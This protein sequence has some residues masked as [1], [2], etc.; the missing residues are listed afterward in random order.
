MKVDLALA[1]SECPERMNVAV[2]DPAPVFEIDTQLE[3]GFGRAHEVGFVDSKA[4]IEAADVREGRLTNSDD[5]N[6]LQLDQ[7]DRAAAGKQ[8]P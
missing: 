5:S 8:R 6:L 7:I 1:A 4:F 3:S 2:A